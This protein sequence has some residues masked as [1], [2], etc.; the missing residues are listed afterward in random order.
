LHHLAA[1][2]L[3]PAGDHDQAV[4]LGDVTAAFVR[5]SAKREREER[6]YPLLPKKLDEMPK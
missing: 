5:S 1:D 4:Q 6:I 2:R 3:H